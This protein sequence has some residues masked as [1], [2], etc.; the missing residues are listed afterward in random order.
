VKKARELNNRKEGDRRLC[1]LC[2]PR[3]DRVVRADQLWA[4]S[5][6]NPGVSPFRSAPMADEPTRPVESVAHD[7]WCEAFFVEGPNV[8]HPCGCED[9]A[10]SA[11]QG[12]AYD[13]QLNDRSGTE[14]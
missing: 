3:R 2:N 12:A 7:E 5:Q 11:T 8:M 6:Q 14:R 10:C 13:E 4:W 1:S 9:R